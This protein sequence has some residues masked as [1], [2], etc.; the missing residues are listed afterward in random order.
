[1]HRCIC[2]NLIP[3][4]P[5]SCFKEGEQWLYTCVFEDIQ[6]YCMNPLH[7]QFSL[8][9]KQEQFSSIGLS[10]LESAYSTI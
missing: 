4:E 5:V 9:L 2:Q 3:D 8:F 6:H 10:L 7:F 1:M